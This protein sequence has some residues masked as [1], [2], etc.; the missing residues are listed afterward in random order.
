MSV[1]A[2]QVCIALG[3]SSVD[4]LVGVGR[5]GCLPDAR[6]IFAH[7]ALN[8][9][10]KQVY[11]RKFLRRDHSTIIKMLHRYDAYKQNDSLFQERL[12]LLDRFLETQN[13]SK[14]VL[15]S[16]SRQTTIPAG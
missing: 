7:R 3:I 13:N 9:G 10:W 16:D 8:E 12:L 4:E 5:Y 6:A 14:D 15:K 2:E 1:L 11:I